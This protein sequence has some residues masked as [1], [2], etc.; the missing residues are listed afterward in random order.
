MCC[1]M[2]SSSLPSSI[3]FI[4]IVTISVSEASMA[5]LIMSLEPNFPVPRNSRE[6]NSLPAIINFSIVVIMVLNIKLS[7][8]EMH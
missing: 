4:A 7:N 5:R 1:I 8:K 3:R 2:S 6:L